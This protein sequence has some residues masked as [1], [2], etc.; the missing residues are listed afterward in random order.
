MLHNN[1]VNEIIMFKWFA[2]TKKTSRFV[3]RFFHNNLT[4]NKNILR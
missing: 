2:I 4:Y 1:N 3:H